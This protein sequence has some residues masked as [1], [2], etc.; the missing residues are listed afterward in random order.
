MNCDAALIKVYFNNPLLKEIQAK[1]PVC[2]FL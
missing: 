1:L 2:V